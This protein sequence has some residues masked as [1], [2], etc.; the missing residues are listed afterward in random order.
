MGHLNG[1]RIAITGSTRGLGRAFAEEMASAGASVVVNG[2]R[3]DLVADVVE[4]IRDAGGTATGFTGSIAEE[5][6]A[7]GLVRTCTETF[8]GIDTIVHN[9]GIVR[10]KTLLKMTAEE[11]DD[12]IAVHLRGAFFCIKHAGL[13]MKDSGGGH[14][15]LVI[16]ASGLSG[17]FGQGNYAAAKEGMMGLQRTAVLELSKSYI[18][19]NCM[20][21]IAETDMTQVVF[22]RANAAARAAGNTPPRP[23]DMG[24]G[25]PAEV[26][27]GMVWLASDKAAHLQGQCLTF[28]GRKTALWSHPAEV[29]VTFHQD[30]WSVEELD[31]HYRE[32]AQQAIWRP[33]MAR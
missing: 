33:K 13:A 7:A 8:G 3:A 4:G 16:S 19:C 23:V 27:Q 28:N 5:A 31:V 10:D 18:R 12:V 6:T 30:A 32:V 22:E 9:A 20:W 1:K 24:F 2:T 29:G 11:F 25:K 15:I 21:P 17:G 26:A 14:I